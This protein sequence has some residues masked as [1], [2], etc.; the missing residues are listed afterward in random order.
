MLKGTVVLV[1]SIQIVSLFFVFWKYRLLNTLFYLF[2]FG[3]ITVN[4]PV[5]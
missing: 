4:P 2:L 5:V 3:I 1:Y